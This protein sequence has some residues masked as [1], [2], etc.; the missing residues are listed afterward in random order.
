VAAVVALLALVA[1]ALGGNADAS[2]PPSYHD[3][4]MADSPAGYWRLGEATGTSA[5]D[6]SGN[7][8]HGVY[9]NGVVLGGAGAL[10]TDG[11][12]SARFDGGNDLVEVADPASGVLDFG[13]DDFTTEAFVKTT[14]NDE[15]GLFAKK[16]ATASWAVT[17]TDDPN[18]AGQLRAN[19]KNGVVSRQLYSTRRVDDGAWH[20]VVV[21]WQR[22][23]GISF[24]IDGRAAGSGGGNMPGDVSNTATLQIGKSP[25]NPYLRGDVDEVAVYRSLLSP[26]RIEDHYAAA[27][28]DN[29]PPQVVLAQPA[30]GDALDDTTPSFSG[31]AGTALGDRATVTV[32]VHAGSDTSGALAQTLTSTRNGDASF[33]AEAAAALAPGTY[34]AIAT[35]TDHA[36]NVGSSSANTFVVNEGGTST[37]PAPTIVSAGDIAGC[38]GTTSGEFQTA[39][40]IEGQP[41]ATVLSLGDHAYPNGTPAE[42]ANCYGPSWGRFK[43]RTRPI[44]GGHEY[45]TPG[46]AGYYGYFGAA[47]GDPSK[48]W[49]SY[50]LGEW[51]IVALN[52]VCDKVGCEAGSEQ[53]QWLRQDLADHPTACTMA[54]LHEPR[55]SSGA[56]HGG[57]TDMEPFWEALYE[58][59]AEVVLSG[60][61]H[62]YE[63]FLPQTPYG[64][65]DT[66]TGITQ[67]VVGSGGFYLY[68]FAPTEPNS[69]YRLNTT[70]GVI[71]MTLESDGYSWKYL[72]TDGAPTTDSGSAGCHGPGVL[73][74][75]DT[76]APDTTI[77]SGPTGTVEAMTARFEFSSNET[78]AIF[79]CRLD[80]AAFSPCNSPKN[81]SALA[82]GSHTFDVRGRDGSG[83]IDPT[84][85]SRTW[86]VDTT[87]PDTSITDG[88]A[89]ETTST[90]ANFSFSANEANAT[91]ECELDGGAWETCNSPRSYTNLAEGSH[92]F[93][94]RATDALGHVELTPASHSWAITPAPPPDTSP[95]DTTII[96]G[97]AG[98]AT[99]SSASFS[100]TSTEFGSTFECRSDA[101][102]WMACVSPQG[103]SDLPDGTHTF[104]V[105]ATDIAGNTDPEPASQTWTIDATAPET[106]MDSGP[107]GAT[108][109]KSAAFGFSSPEAD[110]HFECRLDSGT[111]SSCTSPQVYS[112]LPEGAHRIDVRAVDALGNVDS[113]PASREWTVDTVAPGTAITSGPGPV[114]GSATATLGFSSTETGSTFQCRLDGG[115]WAACPS[116]K[117]YTG[118]ADGTHSFE[119]RA[120]DAAGNIDQSP[121]TRS[122]RVDTTPP[123][124]VITSGT[125]G[126]T[127]TNGASFSFTSSEAGS[128]F[129]C[130]LDGGAW[131]SCSSP[132]V[133]NGVG[134]GTHTFEVRARDAL[135][136]ADATPASRTWTRTN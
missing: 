60:D 118:L 31:I 18:H 135:G 90:A 89:A 15:R 129:D 79:Q 70:Y 99:S 132:K 88:P 91:F 35:Q 30:S 121:A 29:E 113:S 98:T 86:T 93:A 78:G 21:R 47:A 48:G 67:F 130:R 5:A 71:K 84:P 109:S 72:R 73:P 100:F 23:W 120:V 108:S 43:D 38:G 50:D 117:T 24:Y 123:D 1:V 127:S 59:G 2:G 58:H 74:P 116:P 25:D 105:R 95:P 82:D 42:F 96:L 41:N 63:R 4:V 49:Y 94:V 26:A 122:W 46:A 14:A 125:S 136:N 36:G 22:D 19:F 102:T 10:A 77:D 40:L 45:N 55:F 75:R 115:P 76:T 114:V 69:S 62:L 39:A 34:T 83:N 54:L 16:N 51:H 11:D 103:Y 3:E 81:Y 13:S 80:G 57:T 33:S 37:P 65:L 8:S 124:T 97:P 133:Y 106:T 111:W 126:E 134:K 52:A 110:A 131:A 87:A 101:G 27:L 7:A 53:E 66:A 107:T 104:D 44:P 119:V 28:V 20:H 112:T 61:D 64:D 128:A 32:N 56:V 92:S 12:T 68:D 85:A 6:T 17:V 9:K